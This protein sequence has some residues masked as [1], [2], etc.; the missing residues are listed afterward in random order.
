MV[1]TPTQTAVLQ[2][3][4]RRGIKRCISRIQKHWS[5]SRWLATRNRYRLD[6]IGQIELDSPDARTW[7]PT[8]VHLSDY[9]AAS[10]VT[11]SFDGWSFLG[12]ALDA[13]LRGDPYSARHLGY[14][15][16]LRA[17]L[18][19]LATD[20]IG[21]FKN[22]HVVVDNRGRCHCVR[23]GGTHEFTWESLQFWAS[24]SAGVDTLLNSIR[25]GGTPLK[26]WLSH[27]PAS[28]NFIATAWLK[29]WG[30]DLSRLADD[31]ESRNIASY[32]PTAFTSPGPVVVDDTVDSVAR[33]WDMC[34]PGAL[35]GFQV[36]DRHLLRRGV[37]LAFKSSRGRTRGQAPRKYEN[38]IKAMLHGVGPSESTP[39][40][41]EKF[42]SYQDDESN[43]WILDDAN[44]RSGPTAPN[45]SKEVL[46]RAALLLRVATGSVAELLGDVLSTGGSELEFWWS[47]QAVRRSLWSEQNPPNAFADLWLDIRN[48]TDVM[49]NWVE[50]ETPRCYN[51]LWH[52]CGREAGAMATTERVGL[53]GLGL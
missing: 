44:G 33:F 49:A 29:Q 27:Y 9:I 41:W 39:K 12:R 13:E 21:V 40:Q 26:E 4:D 14:Y 25:P 8:H 50:G 3:A 16:E 53:W 30:L 2:K 42:L 45:H 36:L 20:G 5:G 51:R 34:E 24:S 37:E 19:L 46:A 22:R 18:A 52:E 10:T 11:H 38:D 35:G 15:A 48:A 28:I 32:R 7:T 17:A 6:C 43:P 23:A 31:R 1:L 47:D